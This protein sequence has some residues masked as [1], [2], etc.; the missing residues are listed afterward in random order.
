M[1]SA[2]RGIYSIDLA[3]GIITAGGGRAE[4]PHPPW[5]KSMD[6]ASDW[7]SKRPRDHQEGD[8]YVS[9]RPVAGGA[10]RDRG[11]RG[12]MHRCRPGW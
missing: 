10:A 3:K 8:E 12:T 1:G 7:K 11:L 2:L 4:D 6:E 9:G 5:P